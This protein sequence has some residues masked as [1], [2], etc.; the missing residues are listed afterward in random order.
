[1]TTSSCPSVDQWQRL[2]TGA[3]SETE[4]IELGSHLENCTAC[5]R[6]IDQQAAF[7]PTWDAVVR[8]LRVTPEVEV[9]ANPADLQ[10]ILHAL[11][12]STGAT[13]HLGPEIS[14][15]LPAAFFEPT[16][17]AGSLGRLGDYE[18][19]QEVGRGAMGIVYRAFDTKL[20]RV[21]AIKVMSPQ[22]AS[23][24]QA[25]QRFVREGHSA[26]AICHE[27]VVTIHAVAE[28]GGLPYLVMQYIAGKTLQQRLELGGPLSA[29]E[30]L[31]IGRQAAAGLAAAHAQGLVHRDIKPANLL[32]ENGIERVKLTDFGL[33][34]AVD[35]AS[36][37]QTGVIT[38]TPQF[39]A[40]EQAR[41]ESIDHRADLFSLGC[42]LYTLCTG[43]PPF[44]APTTVAVLKR[45]CEDDPRPIRE[46]NSETP[47]WL[48]AIIGK[49]LEKNS[50]RRF[51]SAEEVSEL[52]E[53]CLAHL[54]HPGTPL[55]PEAIALLNFSITPNSASQTRT[56]AS[57]AWWVAAIVAA[58]ILP[59]LLALLNNQIDRWFGPETPASRQTQSTRQTSS[60]KTNSSAASAKLSPEDLAELNGLVKIAE[61]QFEMAKARYE[62]GIVPVAEMVRAE[63]ELREVQVRRARETGDKVAVE[64]Q[65]TELLKLR[66]RYLE[67]VKELHEIGTVASSELL[68]AEKAVLEARRAVRQANQ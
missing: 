35:D 46:L 54:Q 2:L 5:Q 8:K 1:M 33:A 20:Q 51:Q 31:R 66:E 23:Y 34:R 4:Q 63:C 68:D 64:A 60:A 56:R 15:D 29:V 52:L 6:V 67:I 16:D 39:M 62:N 41:G 45:I 26:A 11:K 53:K 24:P 13:T 43:R 22:L 47:D 37:T 12:K 65:L 9:A 42:V 40:P 55:P 7:E 57:R 36:L 49:L 14:P 25:R 19:Q 59:F 58:A 3:A 38:G 17:I 50:S 18:I 30:I 61:K 44:R 32:L 28:A 48:A 27:H 21:V 10:R